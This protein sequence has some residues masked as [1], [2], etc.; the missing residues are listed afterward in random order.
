[1]NKINKKDLII[2]LFY[3][4][5]IIIL[6]WYIF[7]SI[8]NFLR[9]IKPETLLTVFASMFTIFISLFGI[10]YTQKQIKLREI[11]E[12]HR[13]KKIEVYNKFITISTN[14]LAGENPQIPGIKPY[15]DE[16]LVENIFRFKQDLLLWGSPK[17]IQAILLFERNSKNKEFVL[18]SVNNIYKAMRE[19]IGLN[20]SEL[21]DFELIKIFLSDPEEIDS[22]IK[23]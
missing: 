18:E 3:I 2:G 19:D 14:M 11:D 12:A 21:K 13:N 17:V 20:N 10:V 4:F 23:T 6:F 22:L 7:S 5:L 15:T 8:F 16:E 9:D 1:M